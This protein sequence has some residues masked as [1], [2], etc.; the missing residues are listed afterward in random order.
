MSLRV[1]PGV[2]A[3]RAPSANMNARV[4]RAR[5]VCRRSQGFA[6]CASVRCCRAVSVRSVCDT[7]APPEL[8]SRG[9]ESRAKITAFLKYR[10]FANLCLP[11]ELRGS[12]VND[13][14]ATDALDTGAAKNHLQRIGLNRV[15]PPLFD[16]SLPRPSG[17]FGLAKS[18]ASRSSLFQLRSVSSVVS[19]T[20]NDEPGCCGTSGDERRSWLAESSFDP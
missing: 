8:A 3:T 6:R 7:S 11:R 19:S 9:R 16:Q 10:A 1:M 15:C 17:E 14:R 12:A 13:S 18:G 2:A 20:E 4:I 5:V